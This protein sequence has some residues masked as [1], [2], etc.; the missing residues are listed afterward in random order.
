MPGSAIKMGWRRTT[1]D[2]RHETEASSLWKLKVKCRSY[3]YA[4]EVEGKRLPLSANYKLEFRDVL[5]CPAS[6]E[7]LI[8]KVGK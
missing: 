2:P 6:D 8:R 7:S 1:D 5:H 3:S 4:Y